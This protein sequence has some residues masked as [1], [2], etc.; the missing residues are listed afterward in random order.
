MTRKRNALINTLALFGSASTLVCCALPALF[1]SLGAGA[2]LIGLTTAVPQLVWL[3]EHKIGLFGFAAVMLTLS[4]FMQWRNQYAPCPVEPG[5]AKACL[6]LRRI[7]A[8]IFFV[9]VTLFIIGFFFAFVAA[10]MM[11]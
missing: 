1:V 9:S 5:A 4:G 8:G 3:S 6:R 11:R 7:S 2:A 10:G